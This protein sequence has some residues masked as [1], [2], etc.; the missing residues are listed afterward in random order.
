MLAIHTEF[1]PSTNTRAARIK[2]FTCNGH[3]V[4][5]TIDYDLGDVERHFKAAQKLVKE[6]LS[7][8]N[9]DVMVYGGS[10]KGYVFCFP[11]STICGETL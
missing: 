9:A 7:N 10:A 5:E 2:A 4:F 8:C 11:D 1:V 3:K 6:Q